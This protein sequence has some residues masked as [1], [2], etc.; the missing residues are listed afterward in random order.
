MD[1][2]GFQMSFAWIF[3]IV[4]G[5]VILFIAIF[6]AIGLINTGTYEI[7]TKT[8]QALSNLLDPLQTA[9]EEAKINN[10]ELAKETKIFTSCR[11]TGKFGENKLQVSEKIE[12]QGQD[13]SD[14]GGEIP[15][16][17][18]QYIFAEDQIQGEKLYY[19]IMPFKMPYKT[20]DIVIMHTKQYCFVSPPDDIADF[21]EDLSYEDGSNMNITDDVSECARDSVSVCFA[22]GNCDIVVQSACQ[23]ISCEGYERGFVLKNDEELYFIDNLMYAAIFSSPGNYQCGVE[24]LMMR[25]KHLS[26]IYLEKARFVSIKGCGTGLAGDISS[27]MEMAENFN[28]LENLNLIKIKAE[29]INEINRGAECRLF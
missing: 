24:R 2:K 20:A 15:A 26:E 13:W 28:E 19:L 11:L 8:A 10:I 14:L 9:T 17:K 18:N 12:L 16:S 23:G 29:E 7:N 22:H 6:F 1:K 5:A 21:V 27:L 3:A 4:A 25:L